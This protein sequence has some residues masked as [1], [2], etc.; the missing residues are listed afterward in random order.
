MALRDCPLLPEH[1]QSVADLLYEEFL[2]IAADGTTSSARF[3]ET[4]RAFICL[5]WTCRTLIPHLTPRCQS[6]WKYLRTEHTARVCFFT[7]GVRHFRETRPA[8]HVSLAQLADPWFTV[9]GSL[10]SSWLTEGHAAPKNM[11]ADRQR[12]ALTAFIGP[13]LLHMVRNLQFPA[14]V[15][16]VVFPSCPIDNKAQKQWQ[17]VHHGI[18]CETFT[19]RSRHPRPEGQIAFSFVIYDVV[20][21]YVMSP[22]TPMSICYC[23]Q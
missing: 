15:F 23:I 12:P 17:L 18:Y 21:E 9:L 19:R 3:C 6:A 8:L 11:G 13:L 20:P 2:T 7:Y 5:M 14:H 1:L 4:A 10:D 22:C 16:R